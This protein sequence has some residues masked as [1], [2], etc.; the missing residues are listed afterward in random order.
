MKESGGVVASNGGSLTVGSTDAVFYEGGPAHIG[1]VCVP[2][3]VGPGRS[4]RS[5][6]G[7]NRSG[8]APKVRVKDLLFPR[9]RLCCVSSP[10][11]SLYNHAGVDCR[12]M[13]GRNRHP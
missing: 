4:E 5:R 11:F 1:T 7:P 8:G 3:P 13:R 6:S 2:G 10:G 9:G 12:I